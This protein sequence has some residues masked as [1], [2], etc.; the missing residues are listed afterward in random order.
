MP[1]ETLTPATSPLDMISPTE[2]QV[3]FDRDPLSLSDKDV[4]E[5]VKYFRAQRMLWA[6]ADAQAKAAGKR[7]TAPKG[8][9]SASAK[10][11]KA[12]L[13]TITIESLGLV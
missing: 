10:I 4:A 3:L 5:M 8:E 6:D 2:I 13:A 1:E 11:T 7:T 9:A 12:D